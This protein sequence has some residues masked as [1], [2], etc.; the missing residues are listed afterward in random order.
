MVNA[1]DTG[2]RPGAG[3]GGDVPLP[4]GGVLHR[5]DESS[6]HE[7]DLPVGFEALVKP[8]FLMG[9][10]SLGVIPH[11]EH[12]EPRVDLIGA[13]LAIGT[14]ELLKAKTEG[15]LAP[16]EARLLEDSLLDLK[17]QYVEARRGR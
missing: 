7:A 13:R 6:A 15:H 3:L 5:S 9:L 1:D 16:E 4:G 14:L 11:P 8:F 10:A 17:M 12:G 2:N